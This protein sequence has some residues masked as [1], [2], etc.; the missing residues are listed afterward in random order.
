MNTLL[1]IVEK[2][3]KT[4]KFVL[5]KKGILCHLFNYTAQ[6]SN[7][8]MDLLQHNPISH[9]NNPVGFIGKINIMCHYQ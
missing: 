4:N 1:T 6:Q 2:T 8:N 5:F 7:S 9:L 3:N